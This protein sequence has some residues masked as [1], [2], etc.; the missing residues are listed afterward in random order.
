M[1][2][3]TDGDSNASTA[4]PVAVERGSGGM[5]RAAIASCHSRSESRNYELSGKVVR[6]HRKHI[7]KMPDPTTEPD[8][9][10]PGRAVRSL[11]YSIVGDRLLLG[12]EMISAEFSR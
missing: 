6:G 1:R 5:I 9:R 12:C 2:G 10:K 4:A 7:V 8:G 11:A 3:P